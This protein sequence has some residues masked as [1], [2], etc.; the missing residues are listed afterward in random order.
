GNTVVITLGRWRS[1]AADAYVGS[2]NLQASTF[3]H[4]LAHNLYGFHG[5]I[6]LEFSQARP[7]SVNDKIVPRPNCNNKQSSLNYMYQSAGLLD[8][9][10]VFQVNLS[11]EVLQASAGAQDEKSLQEGSG[12]A[13]GPNTPYR[14]R[15]YAPLANVQARFQK[16]ADGSAIPLAAA[17]SF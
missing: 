2:A 11:G 14:L 13:P 1:N 6:T 8:A 5:G 7:L 10:G 15:W 12:L 9:K 3:L 4:E 17:K 16:R